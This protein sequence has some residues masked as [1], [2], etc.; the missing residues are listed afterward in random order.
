MRTSR[1]R[2]F[3]VI[4]L[5]GFALMYPGR[6]GADGRAGRIFLDKHFF[7]QLR[8]TPPIMRD[9][10]IEERLNAIIQA[11]GVVVSI[12]TCPK[13]E[14]NYRIVLEDRD[15]KVQNMKITYY[16]YAESRESIA[17]IAEKGLIDFSGQLVAYTPVTAKR[18]SYIFDIVLEK[19]AMLIE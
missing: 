17:M 4:A 13:Y 7:T 18:S 15:A 9:A 8:R 5:I 1:A 10:F 14:R 12:N 2:V 19:G 11:R 3:A 16:L 6:G